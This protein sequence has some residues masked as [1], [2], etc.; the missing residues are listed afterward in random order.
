MSN[1][2]K[3]NKMMA[4]ING[5]ENKLD[6]LEELLI[7]VLEVHPPNQLPIS[8]KGVV[9]DTYLGKGVSYTKCPICQYNEIRPTDFEC[10]YVLSK[11]KGGM[12]HAHNLRP[13]CDMCCKSLRR[14][15]MK[16]FVLTYFP[17]A[18]ILSTL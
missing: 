13:I 18:P 10:G 12:S 6:K 3:R 14:R 11:S 1:N 4:K 8:L 17:K 7:R 5:L 16:D 2:N 15:D 9:W